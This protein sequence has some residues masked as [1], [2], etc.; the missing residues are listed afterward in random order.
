[1]A[2]VAIEDSRHSAFHAEKSA[3]LIVDGPYI[4]PKLSQNLIEKR[5]A[6]LAKLNLTNYQIPPQFP[7]HIPSPSGLSAEPLDVVRVTHELHH[8]DIEEL[9]VALSTFQSKCFLGYLDISPVPL[10]VLRST[11]RAQ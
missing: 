4:E 9:E 10:I 2:S 8:A 7:N 11:L 1:M 6:L 5:Q 3:E